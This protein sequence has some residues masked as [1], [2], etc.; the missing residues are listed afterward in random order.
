VVATG[1]VIASKLAVIRGVEAVAWPTTERPAHAVVSA[2]SNATN[3]QAPE[4]LLATFSIVG[5]VA[6][7]VWRQRRWLVC[8]ELVIVLLYVGSA[9]IGTPTA[10]LFT[11]LWYDDSYRIAATLPVV[12]IPL[13]TMGVL[14]VG[15]WLSRVPLRA[16]VA[17]RP[18]RALAVPVAVGVVV[19]AATAA[20]SL[21]RNV[22]TVASQFD[23]SGN[24]TL[25][26]HAKL[27]FLQTV[28]RRVP[29]SALV[30]DNPFDGTAYLFAASGTRVLFPQMSRSPDPDVTYLAHNFVRLGQDPRACAL[31]RRYAVEYLVV[32]P[33]DYLKKWQVVKRSFYAGV[34]YPGAHSG[35][36]LIAA[37]GRLRLYQI[38][39]CQPGTAGPVEAAGR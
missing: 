14:A 6:C 37:D 38:T 11:G 34:G 18:A 24:E 29:A 3:G 12:V 2:V 33:D 15:D 31:V 7:F 36:R 23:S 30:A 13:A 27:Q 20:Q 9:A 19:A 32:A 5:M 39:I 26:S 35:F 16:S 4:L 17:A 28:A 25:V 10:R 8:A 21:P 22:H 1:V